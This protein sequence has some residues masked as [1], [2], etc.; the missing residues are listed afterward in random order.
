LERFHASKFQTKQRKSHKSQN[1]LFRGFLDRLYKNTHITKSTE[2]VSRFSRIGR[3]RMK[4]KKNSIKKANAEA[5]IDDLS[6]KNE[7][8]GQ[9]EFDIDVNGSIFA[10]Q[11]LLKH[12]IEENNS[13]RNLENDHK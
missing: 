9:Y 12:T 6:D 3:K 11:E 5:S 8:K 13:K 7:N 2:R 1:N 10:N 4:S